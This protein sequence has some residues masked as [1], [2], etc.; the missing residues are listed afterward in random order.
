MAS[1][2]GLA[3]LVRGLGVPSARADEPVEEEEAALETERGG[4]LADL[5]RQ[6]AGARAG[7][8][9]GVGE[10]PGAERRLLASASE[11]ASSRPAQLVN[12]G[13]QK[14]RGAGLAG[15]LQ[16]CLQKL[17]AQQ[18]SFA[19]GGPAC[20]GARG[21]LDVLILASEPEGPLTRCS[22]TVSGGT[23]LP[24]GA[25]E[26]GDSVCV[27]FSPKHCRDL[28]PTRG[29][30]VRIHFPWNDLVL[31]SGDRVILG[32]FFVSLLETPGAAAR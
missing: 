7:A 32:T 24:E 19:R 23:D 18:E 31:P 9:P 29:E 12:W 1:A 28:A 30:T 4:G 11:L 27:L 6:A 2:R 17:R 5:V 8:A 25:P 22:C 13:P 15:H 10:G 14:A 21:T 20:G 3:G 16:R 26:A